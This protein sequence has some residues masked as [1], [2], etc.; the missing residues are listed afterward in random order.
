MSHMQQAVADLRRD[1][2]NKWKTPTTIDSYVWLVTEIGELG[3]V[4]MRLGY[5]ERQDYVRNRPSKDVVADMNQLKSE[6]GDTILMLCTLANRVGINLDHA[7]QERIHH[8]RRK[9]E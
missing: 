2:G 8:F 7:L 9:Y 6:L 1:I 4:L 3:D 5:G